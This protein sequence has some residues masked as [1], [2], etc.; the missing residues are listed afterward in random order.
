M[1]MIIAQSTKNFQIEIVRLPPLKLASLKM[2]PIPSFGQRLL[3]RLKQ[4]TS[5][6]KTGLR[7]A[8]PTMKVLALAVVGQALINAGNALLP[9]FSGGPL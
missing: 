3:S 4:S 9:S 7:I 5:N 2:A 6:I 8:S 1:S